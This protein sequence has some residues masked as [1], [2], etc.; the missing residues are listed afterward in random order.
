MVIIIY[1]SWKETKSLTDLPI[2][3]S[4]KELFTQEFKKDYFK[5]LQNN[6]NKQNHNIFPPRN[7][8]YNTFNKCPLNKIKVCILGQ[9]PYI[10]PNQAMGLS[11]SVPINC[12]IPPSLR[13]IYKELHTD[14]GFTI[15]NHGD[16]T[17]WV[18]QGV[19][20]LNT[21]LTVQ[22]G[23]SNSHSKFGWQTFTD[24]VIEYI[25]MNCKGVVFILWGRNA[26]SK[27]KYINILKHDVIEC[28]HPSPLSAS[29][30]FFGSKC[31]SECDKL[32][33]D[34]KIN[35]TL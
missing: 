1:M 10:K 13:N 21:S 12:K 15:P 19:F 26:Q 29:R 6:I 32:L 28:V 8:I 24:N 9:D 4:W 3:E 18:E 20:L 27:T 35:W 14:V 30:G 23:K 5:N 25:N 11:F 31:F 22:E 7:L 34:K 33:G 16:L 17:K 2:E